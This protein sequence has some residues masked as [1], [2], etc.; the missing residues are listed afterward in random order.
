[1]LLLAFDT[2]TAM[3]SVA[4]HDGERVL[5]QRTG[6][7]AT[8]HAEVL[9]PAVAGALAEAGASAGDLSA[10]AVGVGPG[11]YTGLRV[12][13]MLARTLGSA[14]GVPVHGVC[15]LDVLAA[16]AD[17]PGP[18]L[19][20]TDARRR[21]VYWASYADPR[22]RDAGPQVGKP[23]EVAT[24]QPVVGRGAA[25]YPEAF[26]HSRGPLDPSAGVL[27]RA[28]LDRS[29]VVLPPDPLYLRRPDVAEPG[30]RKPVR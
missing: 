26:P 29:V 30:A 14:L 2:A 18:F 10:I 6:G 9:A 4:L 27:A 17:E 15:T 22:T 21:E 23:A 1:V 5:A 12:G 19:V 8:R 11:P 3:V 13:V 16:E 20:A 25:L 7:G 24:E 28:V